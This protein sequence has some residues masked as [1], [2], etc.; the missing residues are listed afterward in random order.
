MFGSL[1]NPP[2]GCERLRGPEPGA[3]SDEAL[4]EP[5]SGVGRGRR[6]RRRQARLGAAAAHLAALL[7]HRGLRKRALSYGPPGPADPEPRFVFFSIVACRP[8]HL[9][10]GAAPRDL[11][12]LTVDSPNRAGRHLVAFA[13]SR[14]RRIHCDRCDQLFEFKN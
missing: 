6:R 3:A 12:A 7:Q 4:A 2:L 10:H 9:S 13:I 8:Q 11:R 5:D 1:A 14:W